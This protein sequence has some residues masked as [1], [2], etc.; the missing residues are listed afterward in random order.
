MALLGA[1]LVS[2]LIADSQIGRQ[3]ASARRA[4]EACEVADALLAGWWDRP[5]PMPRD[6]SGDVPDRDGWRW[7]TRVREDEAAAS[8][9]GEILT[10]EIRAPNRETTSE[11][12][13]RVELLVPARGRR[14]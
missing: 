4:V 14:P 7:R 10:V 8:V 11:P 12:D 6:A 5:E 13:A 1:L 3:S 9:G 2:I